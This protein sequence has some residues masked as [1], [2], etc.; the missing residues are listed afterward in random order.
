MRKI[1]LDPD[2][3]A[4]ESFDTVTGADE[5]GTVDGQELQWTVQMHGY[6]CAAMTCNPPSCP[7]FSCISQCAHG[8]IDSYQCTEINIDTQCQ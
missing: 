1:V 2:E 5:R 8:C 4:V 6:T 3:L 7:A